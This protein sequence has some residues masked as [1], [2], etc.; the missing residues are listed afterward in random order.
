MPVLGKQYNMEEYW[1]GK[2]YCGIHL[3]W[4]YREGY[5]DISISNCVRKKLTKL[6]YKPTNR[7]QYCSYEPNPII[8]GKN[9][10]SI[11]HEIEAP[12]LDT[13]KKK[14]VQQILGS[15]LYYAHT[16]GVII[17]HALSAIASEQVNPTERH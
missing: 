2:V 3:K 6:K 4:N 8:Y 11:V 5:V 14:Y 13:Q 16:I 12:L 15:F 9:S 7:L 17:L 10:D 1:K